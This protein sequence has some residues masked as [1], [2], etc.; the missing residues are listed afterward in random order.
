LHCLLLCTVQWPGGYWMCAQSRVGG[1][2]LRA[3]LHVCIAHG[4]CVH[5]MQRRCQV[6]AS[7]AHAAC[8]TA[9]RTSLR[10]FDRPCL[11]LSGQPPPTTRPRM[12]TPPMLASPCCSVTASP[13][14]RLLSA[15]GS[16]S[17]RSRPQRLRHLRHAGAAA[18]EWGRGARVLVEWHCDTHT[19]RTARVQLR[20]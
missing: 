5:L 7:V 10:S 6:L 8:S 14:L 12:P 3:R 9:L 19:R 1:T 18:R 17:T 2:P 20:G 16:P 15:P 13:A 11:A 4:I